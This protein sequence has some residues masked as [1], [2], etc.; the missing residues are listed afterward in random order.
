MLKKTSQKFDPL[1][2]LKLKPD[3]KNQDFPKNITR[4]IIFQNNEPSLKN[5]LL[6]TA[7]TTDN[8]VSLF[9]RGDK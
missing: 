9:D 2:Y 1:S 5:Q 6:F 8:R 3:F 7:T 4:Y